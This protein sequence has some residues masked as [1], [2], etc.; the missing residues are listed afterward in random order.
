MHAKL[1]HFS[2]SIFGAILVY[3]S[4]KT[5]HMASISTSKLEDV[6]LKISKLNS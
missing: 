3:F 1:P 6:P 5:L 2:S 4:N